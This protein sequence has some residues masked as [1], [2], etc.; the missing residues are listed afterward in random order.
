M[1]GGFILTSV[2]LLSPSIPEYKFRKNKWRK[3][4][5]IAGW[6]G[7]EK[8]AGKRTVDSFLLTTVEIKP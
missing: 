4:T 5:C 2:F 7:A 3:V 6:R 1:V 8:M